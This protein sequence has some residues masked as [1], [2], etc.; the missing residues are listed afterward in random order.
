MWKT[1]F[2]NLGK[3]NMF[4]ILN[5]EKEGKC[6]TRTKPIFPWYV[7]KPN[8]LQYLGQHGR[9]DQSFWSAVRGSRQGKVR[10]LLPW[11][12]EQWH[13][14][15]QGAACGW[16]PESSR[17][18][19]SF[20]ALQRAAAGVTSCSEMEGKLSLIPLFPCS[21]HTEPLAGL[22]GFGSCLRFFP[23]S[24]QHWSVLLFSG[25][26]GRDEHTQKGWLSQMIEKENLEE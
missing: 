18:G 9:Q 5:W 16:Q 13:L 8:I 1:S 19:N 2:H 17:N 22:Q 3:G 4:E 25:G 15:L 6:R 14:L 23:F 7:C 12:A 20:T 24:G 21:S 26:L 10:S 11:A